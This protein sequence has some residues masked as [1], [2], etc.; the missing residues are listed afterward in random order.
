MFN[1]V[2]FVVPAVGGPASTVASFV[3]RVGAERENEI[4]H[5]IRVQMMAKI[6]CDRA[7]CRSDM[8][9]S[10]RSCLCMSPSNSSGCN[11]A[12]AFVVWLSNTGPDTI[13]QLFMVLLAV[14]EA[15]IGFSEGVS[16][17]ARSDEVPLRRES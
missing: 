14:M 16:F 17:L 2:R 8:D 15:A 3:R 12:I 1:T 13:H 6:F 11:V 9:E 7:N 4:V 5:I 10:R